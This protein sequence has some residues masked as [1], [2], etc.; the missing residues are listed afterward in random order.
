MIRLPSH[1]F[2][3]HPKRHVVMPERSAWN[4]EPEDRQI[5]RD[6]YRGSIG[7]VL[8]PWIMRQLHT[9]ETFNRTPSDRTAR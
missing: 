8:N 5:N 3:I 2:P 1:V 6:T 7:G 4:T 9:E